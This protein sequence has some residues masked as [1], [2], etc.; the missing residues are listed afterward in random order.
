MPAP[1][2]PGSKT[3]GEQLEH[4]VAVARVD[5]AGARAE[6]ALDGEH[7]LHPLEG[8]ALALG[9]R[10]VLPAEAVE[11]QREAAVPPRPG[12]LRGL[13]HRVLQQGGDHREILRR[14]GA[15]A[16][17]PLGAVLEAGVLGSCGALVR[18]RSIRAPQAE[19]FSSTRS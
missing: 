9:G 12:D 3:S 15:Q 13:R 16:E 5:A 11:Q 10:R 6:H 1:S 14:L 17:R 19:S 8:P 2:S 4:E 7:R 18:C